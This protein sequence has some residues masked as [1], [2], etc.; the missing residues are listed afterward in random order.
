MH[1]YLQKKPTLQQNSKSEGSSVVQ[2]R[3]D[4]VVQKS[5]DSVVQKSKD[6]VVQK[7]KDS[8]VQK[9]KDNMND[10]WATP[11]LDDFCSE[12]FKSV[13][14]SRP[15]QQKEVNSFSGSKVPRPYNSVGETREHF[16]HQSSSS[17][18]VLEENLTD[19]HPPAMHYFF[20]HDQMVQKLVR[21]RLQH[22]VPIGAE[23]SQGNEY[24]VEENLNYRSQFGQC[25]DA[26]GRWVTPNKTTSVP[27]DFGK[28]R[29]H[30]GGTQSGSGH[31]FTGEDGRKV[32]VSKNGQELTGRGAYQQYKKESGKGFRK[33]KKKSGV[34]KEGSSGARRGTAAASKASSSAKRSSA[35][36]RKR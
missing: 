22:F 3:K 12:Y 5:K 11:A 29:V 33:F 19:S 4:S 7:S 34:K 24:G 21:E 30:A 9:S 25:G 23:T 36:K 28:R 17:R 8:V 18:V 15:S 16:Q 27:T 14:D 31:W 32:Y 1:K 6:S 10:S 26:N 20:H 13:Q 2:K 35:A